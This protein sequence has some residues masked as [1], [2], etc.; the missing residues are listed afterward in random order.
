M[1]GS[2]A[3]SFGLPYALVSDGRLYVAIADLAASMLLF[4]RA[5]IVIFERPV[6]LRRPGRCAADAHEVVAVE[7]RPII[8]ARMGIVGEDIIGTGT[9]F[10][11]YLAC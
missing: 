5:A 1:F 3:R 8:A 4:K 6:E 7:E 9:W 2:L 10:V 11:Y